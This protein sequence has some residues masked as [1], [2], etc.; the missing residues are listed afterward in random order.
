MWF[1]RLTG[2]YSNQFQFAPRIGF[3]LLRLIAVCIKSMT[4]SAARNDCSHRPIQGRWSG[5]DF[6]FLLGVLT[7]LVAPKINSP[8][9]QTTI[10][11][12]R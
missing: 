6:V 2:L 3:Q 11:P 9:K 8:T 7:N 12:S 1:V 10:E 5:L 4:E